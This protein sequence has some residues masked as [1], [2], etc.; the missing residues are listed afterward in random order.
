MPK[1]IISVD[2]Y[3]DEQ[4]GALVRKLIEEAGGVQVSLDDIVMKK[5]V[6]DSDALG[7]EVSRLRSKY[8]E[9]C[10]CSINTPSLCGH[11]GAL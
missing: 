8:E 2:E 10:W 4:L 6:A 11:K 7:A 5:L 9:R 3:T 1:V